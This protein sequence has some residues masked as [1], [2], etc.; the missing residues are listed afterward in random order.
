MKNIH[1]GV[2]ILV[3]LVSSLKV[4]LFHGCFSRFL[5]RTMVLYYVNHSFITA[6]EKIRRINQ[7]LHFQLCARDCLQR[8]FIYSQKFALSFDTT[9][10]YM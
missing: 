1:G 2:L 10:L 9:G 3:T 5:N 6:Y 7:A 8:H 4:I